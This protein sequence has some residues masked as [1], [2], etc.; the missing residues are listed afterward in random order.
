M[1]N[2]SFNYETVSQRPTCVSASGQARTEVLVRSR[3][4]T[5]A[6]RIAVAAPQAP[7]S[8]E[9]AFQPLTW[10]FL[11]VEQDYPHVS[12][13]KGRKFNLQCNAI[14][15]FAVKWQVKGHGTGNTPLL[16]PAVQRPECGYPVNLEQGAHIPASPH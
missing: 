13:L 7:D 15:W 1:D 10:V 14:I 8:A 9:A 11:G 5:R 4:K 3:R 12:R 2:R 6:C 16:Q